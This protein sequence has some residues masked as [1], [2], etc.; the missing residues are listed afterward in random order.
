[1]TSSD[2]PARAFVSVIVPVYQNQAGAN[3]CLDALAC[4]SYP[5]KRFE[6]LL[7]DNASSLELH[8]NGTFPFSLRILHCET[9]GSYAARNAGISASLGDVLAF[10]DADCAPDHEWLSAGVD[11][12]IRAGADSVI[13]G[14]I[15]VIQPENR[16]GTGLYQ[17]ATGFQQKENIRDKGFSATANLLCWRATFDVIGAFDARL[18]SCADR[19]WA[20]RA[21][22]QGVRIVYSEDARVATPPRTTLRA[23]IRQARRVA[24]G[25]QYLIAHGL[26]WGGRRAILPH[27]STLTGLSWI[28]KQKQLS[29]WERIKVL[30]AACAIRLATAIELLRLRFGSRAER[31]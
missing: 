23:A 13:G 10:T 3:A 27:R 6:V 15:E 28:M 24:A 4:Q 9:V 31:R 30:S 29:Y 21:S 16:S 12:L 19:E 22:K 17:Y 5:P 18:Y 1:M 11:A 20:W 26:D 2:C 25:R 8:I 7:V 14:E